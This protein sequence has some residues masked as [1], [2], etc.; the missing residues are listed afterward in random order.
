MSGFAAIADD[1]AMQL[2]RLIPF[3]D[4][5]DRRGRAIRGGG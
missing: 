3:E 2:G 1:L 4:D 5:E